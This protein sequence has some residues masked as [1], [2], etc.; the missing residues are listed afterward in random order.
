[1]DFKRPAK[2]SVQYM[3]EEEEGSIELVSRFQNIYAKPCSPKP[4]CLCWR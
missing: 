1:L 2:G 4:T 3:R